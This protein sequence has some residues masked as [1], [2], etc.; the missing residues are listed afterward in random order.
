MD[1]H[2]TKD[3]DSD[4]GYILMQEIETHQA[5]SQRELSQNTGL[6]LGTVN[7]LLQ[8]MI[9]Q[10]LVK[11]E[12]I[13]ANRVIYML[14]PIGMAEKAQK[15]VRYIRNHYQIIQETK[16]KIIRKLDQYH[17]QFPVL[18]FCLPENELDSLVKTATEEYLAKNPQRI[19]RLITA[20]DVEKASQLPDATNAVIL[21]LPDDTAASTVP[22]AVVG[23]PQICLQDTL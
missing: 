1:V 18:Y 21:Y 4:K 15:T 5:I 11:M 16:M 9:Q 23:I 8:K 13:P 22:Q 7:L 14:T 10:G 12:T 19:V 3:S 20:L 2:Q 6:S 17:Q